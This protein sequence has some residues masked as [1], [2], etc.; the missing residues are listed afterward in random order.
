MKLNVPREKFPAAVACKRLGVTPIR[1][2]RICATARIDTDY[3]E[4]LMPTTRTYKVIGE[5]EFGVELERGGDLLRL[6][7]H[8]PGWPFSSA[9][10]KRQIRRSAPE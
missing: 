9:G 4:R 7:T 2:I 8:S 6:R 10:A 1:S 5:D 3:Q